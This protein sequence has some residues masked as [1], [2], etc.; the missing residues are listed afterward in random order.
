MYCVCDLVVWCGSFEC[1]SF[2]GGLL[3][4]VV[5][6]CLKREESDFIGVLFVDQWGV[7]VWWTFVESYLRLRCIKWEMLC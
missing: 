3:C 6:V 5:G 4:D 1:D 2:G 7:E